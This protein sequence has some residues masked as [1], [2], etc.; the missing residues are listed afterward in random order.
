MH[1]RQPVGELF[2]LFQ[3]VRGEEHRRALEFQLADQ[4]P[5]VAAGL[6]VE[7]GGRLVEEQHLGPSEQG[8]REVEAPAFAAG[9]LLDPHGAT[10]GQVGHVEGFVGGPGAAGAAR[11]HAYGLQDGQLRREAALLEHHADAVPH[12]RPL[13]ERVVAQHP[14]RSTGGS[15]LAFEEFEGGGLSGAVGAQQ[16]E[17]LTAGDREVDALDGVEVAVAPFQSDG[18]DDGVHALHTPGGTG[19][20][21]VRSVIRCV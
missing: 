12:R 3:V 11:P 14:D 2:G 7:A 15:G 9:E 1:D 4:F 20:G 13:A 18:F 17:Q 10:V 21:A 19:P 8:Q 16:G 5:G 6:G